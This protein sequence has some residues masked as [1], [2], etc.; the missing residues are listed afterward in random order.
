MTFVEIHEKHIRRA[1]Y[2]A[3]LVIGVVLTM[4]SSRTQ[5]EDYFV[6]SKSVMLIFVIPFLYIVVVYWIHYQTDNAYTDE[7]RS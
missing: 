4:Y 5:P 2:Y 6:M 1:K 3:F 7:T